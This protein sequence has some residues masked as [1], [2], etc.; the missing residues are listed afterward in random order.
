MD[1]K[2]KGALAIAFGL[3]ALIVPAAP[4]VAAARSVT[5]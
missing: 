1:R 2:A 4:A 3:M 5:A